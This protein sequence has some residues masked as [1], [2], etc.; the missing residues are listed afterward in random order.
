MCF[1]KLLTEFHFLGGGSIIS[2]ILATT[3][4]Q[5]PKTIGNATTCT[6]YAIS[7]HKMY[8]LILYNDNKLGN[9][10]EKD[11]TSPVM[12]FNDASRYT[13]NR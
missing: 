5:V 4:A 9:H 11:V 1:L 6:C 12:F 3:I 8:L 7:K 10:F 2:L 13:L